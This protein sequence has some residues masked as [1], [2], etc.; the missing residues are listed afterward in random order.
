NK[1]FVFIV[2][3]IV[4]ALSSGFFAGSYYKGSQTSS[5][6]SSMT[7][8]KGTSGSFARTKTS[9]SNGGVSGSIISKDSQSITIKLPGGGSQI[10]FVN[11][12]TNIMKSVSGS[13]DD[14][15]TDTTVL[16]SGS[17]N[18]DGSSLTATSI[19]I[20][21]QTEVSPAPQSN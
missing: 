2:I 19:N 4:I 15:S 9:G 12:S 10:V 18:S 11:P 20:R 13:T 7:F 16:V 1:H 8:A 17:T 14:L 3:L 21:N 5:S 6:Q